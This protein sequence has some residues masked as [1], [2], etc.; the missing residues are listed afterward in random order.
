[1]YNAN[2]VDL[3]R[4]LYAMYL[5]KSRADLELEAQGE[6]ETLAKHKDRLYTLADR[7]GI[8]PSQIVVYQEIVSGESIQ[9]RPE[10]LRL[11]DDVY[12]RKY[13]GVL[14]VEVE[15]LARGNT[16]D[17]GEVADAFTYS[18]T[19]IITPVKIYDPQ[20]EYDQEYFEFGLFMSR[21]EYKTHQRRMAAG[22]EA[23][24]RAGNYIFAFPPYGYD[25]VRRAKNDRFL[26]EKPEEAKVVR[27]IFD[28]YTED[29]MSIKWIAR[30][31][32]TMGITPSRS[33]EWA[34][35]TVRFMLEN[36]HY[37]GKVCYGNHRTV[38]ERDQ[39]TGKITKKQ[40]PSVAQI[41]EGKH[42]AIISE[43]QFAKAH[44]LCGANARTKVST[45][46]VNPLSGLLRCKGCGRALLLSRFGGDT[47]LPR[48]VHARILSCQ[49]PS[50][51]VHTL[52]DALVESLK[53]YIA[54]Y[55]MKIEQGLKDDS[56][57]RHA[58]MI[59]SMESELSKLQSRK[60]KLMDSW[61][62]DDGMYTREEYLERKQR[63]NNSISQLSERIAEEK[64]N[65][66]APVDYSEK[67]LTLH[68]V[69]DCIGD[70]SISAKEKNIF[71]RQFI[72]KI[73]YD[74][75]DEGFKRKRPILEVFLK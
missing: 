16:R 59:A 62:A 44:S 43:E 7:L 9:N 19:K 10:M 41:Y 69:L 74:I 6:G 13:A 57:E 27:M 36:V 48:Y 22:K 29:R 63:Y 4:D 66:P 67:I 64:K 3:A 52:L 2:N 14:V 49:K 73:T 55:E 32:T 50:C 56:V 51:T 58:A 42:K 34:T 5:R 60:S 31:L 1:M 46:M 30:Q 17:Q 8:P 39:D 70:E 20:D 53:E 23:A 38:K 18:D 54:D 45:E 68:A 47:Q 15:R 26:V 35:T 72:E 61:E 65:A 37:I 11:L 24:A 75:V 25:I 28:W 33:K 21:R 12:A 40:K 71:L